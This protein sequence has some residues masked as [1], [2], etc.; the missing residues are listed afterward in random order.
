MLID[1][2]ITRLKA[3]VPALKAVG[4]AADLAL[5]RANAAASVQFPRA[6]VLTVAETGQNNRFLSGGVAQHRQVRLAVVLVVRNVR[7]ASGVAAGGDM[8]TLRALT[9]AA[10][11]GYTPADFIEPLMFDAGKLLALQDG[12]LW[13][14]DEYLTSFDRRNV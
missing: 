12:E 13:W 4:T 7:D 6:Y 14:Q 1:L 2:A 3:Q 8:Q 11:F 5:A 10:L 9:D